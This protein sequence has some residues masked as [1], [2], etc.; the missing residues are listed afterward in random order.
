MEQKALLEAF[1]NLSALAIERASYAEQAAQSEMLRRTEKLQTAL[2]NS[3]SHELRTPLASITG[4]LT[5]LA[6]SERASDP[7]NNSTRPLPLTCLPRRPT[8]PGSSTAWW[9]TC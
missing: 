2:L 1:A 9:R 3:I 7:E 4:V 5:S 6:E 8:R